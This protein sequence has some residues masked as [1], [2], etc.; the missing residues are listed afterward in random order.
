M[1]DP[2]KLVTLFDVSWFVLIIERAQGNIY[3]GRNQ[4]HNGPPTRVTGTQ[5]DGQRKLAQDLGVP[6]RRPAIIDGHEK[7]LECQRPGLLPSLCSTE[8]VH[9][10]VP[11]WVCLT[12]GCERRSSMA[13]RPPRQR[14]VAC[15]RAVRSHATLDPGGRAS[16]SASRPS[17]SEREAEVKSPSKTVLTRP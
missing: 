2:G 10:F 13:V 8:T 3:S 16:T 9:P 6:D 11:T 12:H 5:Y 1:C 14:R 4:R 7:V 17:Y 15:L